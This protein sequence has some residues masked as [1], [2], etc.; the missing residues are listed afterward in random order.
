[1]NYSLKLEPSKRNME[2]RLKRLMEASVKNTNRSNKIKLKKEFSVQMQLYKNF[3]IVR[4]KISKYEVYK[5]DIMLDWFFTLKETKSYID[6]KI[7]KEGKN[8]D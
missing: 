8:G 3:K 5:N 7:G 4:T 6:W 1:M 2:M